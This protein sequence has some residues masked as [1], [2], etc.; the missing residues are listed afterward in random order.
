MVAAPRQRLAIDLGQQQ[1][2]V[3]KLVDQGRNA[4]GRPMDIF[5][6]RGRHDPVRFA[7]GHRELMSHIGRGVGLIQGSQITAGGDPLAQGIHL[8]MREMLLERCVAGQHQS[9]PRLAAGRQIGDQAKFFQQA[10]G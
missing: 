9:Y 6:G 1:R 2:V 5:Q 10:N 3:A 4:V 7:A 8:R